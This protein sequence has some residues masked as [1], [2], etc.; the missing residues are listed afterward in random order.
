YSIKAANLSLNS[1]EKNLEAMKLGLRTSVDMEFDVPSYS[2][3]LESWYNP[4]TQ[5][6]EFYEAGNTTFEGRLTLNQPIVFTNGQ[7][8]VI[9]NVFGRTQ[10]SAINQSSKDFFSNLVFNIHQPLFTYNNLSANLERAELNLEIA[11]RNYTKAEADIIYNATSAFYDLFKTKKNLEITQE[12][13]RQTELSYETAANKFKA[14]LIAEVEAMQLEIDLAGARN[15][16]L[17]AE[18]RY[19]ESND[20]L[21]I[22]IGLES[23]EFIDVAPELAYNPVIIN[24]DEAISFAL[25]NRPDLFNNETSIRL[26]EMQIDEIDARKS[27][28]AELNLNYGINKVDTLF[29]NVF[30]NFLQNRSVTFTVSLPVW[31]W[32]R[33]SREVESAEA[34][35]RLSKLNYS[36]QKSN[37]I[38]EIKQLVNRI[39]SAKARVEVLSKSVNVAEK[40]YNISLERFRAGN[41]TSFDLSQMQLR[42]TDAKTNSLNALIDYKLA[43]A[44]LVRKTLHRF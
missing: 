33:N 11:K 43:L 12:R 32:G 23:S 19:K 29:N 25:K 2:K 28:K 21:K 13:V 39:E 8:S 1:S 34:N 36:F 3:N 18:R 17:S 5:R 15:E 7:L 16:L 20:N 31:D 24:E 22:L 41:I 14:G 27:I 40:S 35:L 44:D 37:I 6:K 4:F 10:F 26:S 42:L 38:N 30:N 9:G